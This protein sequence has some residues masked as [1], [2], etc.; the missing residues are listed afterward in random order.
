[1]PWMIVSED[2]AEGPALRRN[3]PLMDAHW[4]YEQSIKEKILCAGSLRSDD[5]VTPIGS[6]LVLDVESREEAMAL[7]KADPATVAG[8]RGNVTVRRWNKAI[9]NGAV[10]D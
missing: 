2:T 9:F 10:C 8:L 6:L 4:A 1:M 5:G 3:R 7:F